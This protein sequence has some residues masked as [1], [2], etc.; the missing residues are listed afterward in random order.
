MLYQQLTGLLYG[1]D[2]TVWGVG[3]SGSG[4][5][6]NNPSDEGLV[7]KGP[8]PT[9]NYKIVGPP[10]DSPTHGPYVLHLKPDDLTRQAI[11]ALGRDPD[12]FLMHGDSIEHPGTA[13]E[14]CVIMDRAVR[15]RVWRSGDDDL[16]VVAA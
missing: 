2:N 8:I 1:A 15:E 6:Q 13:S 11:I 10:Y 3:Y 16:T 9:G 5:S 12:S 4:E 14:G 7:D